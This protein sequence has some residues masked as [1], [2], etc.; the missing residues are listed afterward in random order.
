MKTTMAD[1]TRRGRT[2][3]V[4]GALALTLALPAS[5]APLPAQAG[6]ARLATGDAPVVLIGG[7]GQ[8]RYG[9]PVY[10]GQRKHYRGYRGYRGPR[11]YR[12]GYRGNHVYR[13][14]RPYR[15]YPV[16]RSYQ[17]YYGYDYGYGYGY[18]YWGGA[19]AAGILGVII[20]QGLGQPRYIDP[21]VQVRRGR[22]EPWTP[23]W[24]RYCSRKYRSFNPNTGYYLAYSG[25]YRFCR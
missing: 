6:P 23:S 13:P 17:P 10:R 7:R 4:C 3:C 8:R 1:L 21:P 25:R 12:H 9:G 20:G 2:W 18:D 14:Y 11:Y 5:F 24:Y 22:Y 19:A 16:Y 15:P